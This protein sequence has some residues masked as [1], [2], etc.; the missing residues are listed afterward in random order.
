MYSGV[1]R[2]PTSWK[3]AETKSMRRSR[4]GSPRESAIFSQYA[5]TRDEWPV[6]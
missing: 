5:A 1:E 6:M 2:Y 4:E 3:A